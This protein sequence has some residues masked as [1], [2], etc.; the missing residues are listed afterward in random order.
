MKYTHFPLDAKTLEKAQTLT[1]QFKS[2]LDKK[3]K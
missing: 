3:K 1:I 2:I